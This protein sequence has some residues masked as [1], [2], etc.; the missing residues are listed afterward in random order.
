MLLRLRLADFKFNMQLGKKIG[1]LKDWALEAEY[2]FLT[3]QN[4]INGER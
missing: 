3:F 4:Q 2:R 1:G